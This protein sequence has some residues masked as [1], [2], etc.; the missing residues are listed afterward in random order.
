MEYLRIQKPGGQKPWKVEELKAGLEN[1][2]IKNG[3][4][5]TAPEV[6]LHPYL[7]SARSVERCFGGLVELRKTLGLDTQSDLREGAHSSARAHRIN[8]RAHK[9]EQE[10][11]E[12]LKN[13]FGKQ[14][15]HREYFFLDD[16]RTRADFFVYDKT[17]GFCVDVFY[18]SD[19]RNL[20]G[21][22]N[23]KLAKYQWSQM[24]QYPVI[25]L[26][27]NNDLDQELLDALIRNKKN[28]LQ[29][30]HYL[31][32]WDSFTKFCEKRRPLTKNR[33]VG[34]QELRVSQ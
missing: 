23:S 32:S 3:R 7:P 21:C 17:S 9:V 18:P 30:G 8:N 1:F 31:Y 28:K 10:V 25:F 15:V 13:R 2:Y 34:V 33:E 4:Y 26:Q 11:Y 24:N 16:K 20:I 5:P 6:D 27:M 29:T 14:F 19:R 12:F 22:I